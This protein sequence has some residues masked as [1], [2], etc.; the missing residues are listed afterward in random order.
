MDFQNRRGTV[1]GKGNKRR[2][3]PFGRV[4]GQALWQYLREQPR[5]PDAPLF[6]SDRGIRAGEAFT[7]SGVRDV[8]DLSRGG[9]ELREALRRA[10]AWSENILSIG[11]DAS[12][13]GQ[14]RGTV[15]SV[16]SSKGGV[17]NW[18]PGGDDTW[19]SRRLAGARGSALLLASF[20]LDPADPLVREHEHM[21]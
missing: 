11:A 20:L 16:F 14:G 6:I 3:L 10:M 9:E 18:R 2:A 15:I 7:R 19:P 21:V 4:C 5:E 1:L 8:V 13:D 17:A 12:P